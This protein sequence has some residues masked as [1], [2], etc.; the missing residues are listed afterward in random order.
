[1]TRPTTPTSLLFVPADRPERFDKACQSGSSAIIIDLE[2]TVAL[3]DKKKA[4]LYISEYDKQNPKPFW[5]RINNNPDKLDVMMAD[6]ACLSQCRHLA[7]VVLPKLEQPA[8]ISLVYQHLECAIIGVIETV[9]G[10]HHLPTLASCPNLLALS[11]GLLDLGNALGVVH[12][13]VGASGLLDSIRHQLVI[14]SSLYQLACPIETI[15]A[16]IHDTAKLI[17]QAD[18]AYQMGFGG[19]LCIHPKQVAIVNHSYQPSGDSRL[20]AQKIIHHHQATGELAFGIDG[21]MVD[22]PLI[23]WAKHIIASSL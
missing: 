13:S 22:L 1:M 17:K 5:V 6:L 7:G 10:L 20:F 8:T 23:E 14:Y 12:G 21:V 11:F 4:R 16:D 9:Q 18:H 3:S 2:D 19:Q 15:C